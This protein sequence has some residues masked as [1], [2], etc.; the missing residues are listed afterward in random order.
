MRWLSGLLRTHSTVLLLILL[1]LWKSLC[2]R[3]VRGWVILALFWRGCVRLLPL[4]GCLLLSFLFGL[5]IR[6][7]LLWSRW[8]TTPLGCGLM[9]CLLIGGC[10]RMFVL[11]DGLRVS[12]LARP[13]FR[14]RSMIGG[15]GLAWL[16]IVMGLLL[17]LG[18]WCRF[19]FLWL[20]VL[21]FTLSLMF[22]FPIT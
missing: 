8:S 14:R 15:G 17:F 5:L 13:P 3:L 21:G 1:V 18:L 7:L 20:M 19:L 11:G 16:L 22:G 4:P 12:L 9:G 10:G 2:I 6:L